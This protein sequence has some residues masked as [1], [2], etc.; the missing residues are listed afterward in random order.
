MG[1]TLI[2]QF[3]SRYGDPQLDDTDHCIYSSLY[4]GEGYGTAT[5]AG[6]SEARVY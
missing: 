5:Q 2:Q 3:D 1:S 4:V 6:S